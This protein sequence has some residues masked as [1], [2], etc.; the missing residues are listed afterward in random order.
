MWPTVVT[1]AM[2]L[3][4]GSLDRRLRFELRPHPAPIATT[5]GGLRIRRS[6]S[7]GR[8]SSGSRSSTTDHL[9]TPRRCQAGLLVVAC[10]RLM[11][12]CMGSSL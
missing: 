2:H 8:P 4:H 5:S 10:T 7:F 1:T 3:C 9:V 12:T 11:Q 6:L